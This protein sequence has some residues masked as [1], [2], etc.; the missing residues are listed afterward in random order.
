MSYLSNSS[1]FCLFE[2]RREKTYLKPQ[3]S[4]GWLTVGDASKREKF[5]LRKGHHFGSF[6]DLNWIITEWHDG[7]D[8]QPI[9]P[10][11]QKSQKQTGCSVS[12]DHSYNLIIKNCWEEIELVGHLLTWAPH[13][14]SKLMILVS[15]V[16]QS[17]WGR[18]FYTLSIP[19]MDV[20]EYDDDFDLATDAATAAVSTAAVKWKLLNCAPQNR[21][22]ASL[23]CSIVHLLLRLYRWVQ[24]QLAVP[25]PLIR[26]TG[27]TLLSFFAF[28]LAFSNYNWTMTFTLGCFFSLHKLNTWIAWHIYNHSLP[29]IILSI[30]TP[31]QHHRTFGTLYAS[32]KSST[33]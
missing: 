9:D 7:I 23:M 32:K 24:Q 5:S 11:R 29:L 2:K 10:T 21:P 22:I 3:W 15:C 18:L 26:L 1:S 16:T 6:N 27:A 33:P 14:N 25:D 17:R 31:H 20:V 28:A 12:V 4:N 13:Q 8:A 19:P 30:Q